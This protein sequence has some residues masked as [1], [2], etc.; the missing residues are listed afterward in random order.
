LDQEGLDPRSKARQIND[1][2]RKA[3]KSK[4]T[5]KKKLIVGTKTTVAAP[6]KTSGRKFKMVDRRLKKDTQGMQRAQKK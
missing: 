1:L 6:N 5:N 3:V 2:Y 4:N